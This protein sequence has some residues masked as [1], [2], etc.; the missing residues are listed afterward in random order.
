MTKY[1][2][3]FF[4]ENSF[5]YNDDDLIM[6]EKEIEAYEN[7]LA[8]IPHKNP[9]VKWLQRKFIHFSSC[10]IIGRKA[11]K[12]YRRFLRARWG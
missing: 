4:D 7:I 12:E 3:Q 2:K 11:R 8:Q 6:S 1:M 9:V 10:L 5:V